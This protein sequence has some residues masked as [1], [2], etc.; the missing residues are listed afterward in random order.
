MIEF[1]KAILPERQ[2]RTNFLIFI[3]LW[4]TYSV[5]INDI[6]IELE[7]IGGNLYFNI[8]LVASLEVL[9]SFLSG[10]LIM[11][12][13]GASSLKNYSTLILIVFG[14][15][16]LAPAN[17]KISETYQVLFLILLMLGK[18]FSEIITNLIYIFAPKYLTNEFT[19]FFL[20]NVRLFSRVCLLFLPHI[21]FILRSMHIHVF[22]FLAILWACGRLILVFLEEEEEGLPDLLNE[23]QVR[24]R[25]FQ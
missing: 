23:Y 24:D 13:D 9:A 20:I 8:G 15:F 25:K 21:N 16:A 7:T 4:T 12:S 11:K 10:V 19:S 14:L 2:I 1:F 3:F 22:V 18:L 5:T 17:S 6:L